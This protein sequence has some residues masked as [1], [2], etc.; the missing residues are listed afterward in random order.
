MNI[1]KG[2]QVKILKGK[3]AGKTAKVLRVDPENNLA[4]MEGVNLHTKNV[5]AK[6]AGEK[7]QVV[8][9]PAPIHVSSVAL[10]CPACGQPTRV[11]HRQSGNGPK[12]RYCKQCNATI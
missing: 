11:G 6:R 3:D 12:E 1:K 2:D 4:T 9:L 7:G 10:V 5:R 8:K